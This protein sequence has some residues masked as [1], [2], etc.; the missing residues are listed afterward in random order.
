MA[1]FS[2]DGVVR[3]VRLDQNLEM[4]VDGAGVRKYAPGIYRVATSIRLKGTG[5]LGAEDRRSKIPGFD[6][7]IFK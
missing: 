3:F 5:V 2:R 4:E 1:I 6:Q 7:E